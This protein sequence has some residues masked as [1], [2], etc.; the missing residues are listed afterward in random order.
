M[1]SVWA[2]TLRSTIPP[3]EIGEADSE[4]LLSGSLALSEAPSL[5]HF[6]RGLVGLGRSAAQFPTRG[7]STE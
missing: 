3:V 5:T 4:T 6:V 1:K 2:T 7:A